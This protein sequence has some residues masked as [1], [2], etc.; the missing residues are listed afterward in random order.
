MVNRSIEAIIIYTEIWKLHANIHLIS[1]F[2]LG[3][4]SYV[5]QANLKLKSC[6]TSAGITGIC[7]H[8]QVHLTYFS[9]NSKICVN[10][11]P[12]VFI[13]KVSL[14]HKSLHFPPTREHYIFLLLENT[15]KK[16]YFS[17]FIYVYL[18]SNIEYRI[19]PHIDHSCFIIAYRHEH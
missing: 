17:Y 14:S 3:R 10:V 2:F 4:V 19:S 5:A 13:S 7:H 18:T 16:N 9:C 12:T 15:F 11:I 1:F 8:P 6:L